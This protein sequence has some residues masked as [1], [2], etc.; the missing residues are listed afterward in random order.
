MERPVDVSNCVGNLNKK[1]ELEKLPTK[2]GGKH[3]ENGSFVVTA[4]FFVPNDAIDKNGSKQN[5]RN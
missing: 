4:I 5:D 1:N 3:V 2:H